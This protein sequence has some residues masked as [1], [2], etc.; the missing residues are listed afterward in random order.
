M[1]DLFKMNDSAK[2]F[3]QTLEQLQKAI[4]TE[5]ICIITLNEQIKS[6]KELI[7]EET[8]KKSLLP[9]SIS[10]QKKQ[11]QGLAMKHDIKTTKLHLG[12]T[13]TNDQIKNCIDKGAKDIKYME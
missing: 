5:K 4:V 13:H 10:L 8:H 9:G 7:K 6:I 3:Q 11:I 1:S 2:L 12:L